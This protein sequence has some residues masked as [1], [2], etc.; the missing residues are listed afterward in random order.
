MTLYDF[1]YDSFC[2]QIFNEL[3]RLVGHY[4]SHKDGSTVKIRSG[5]VITTTN[6]LKFISSLRVERAIDSLSSAGKL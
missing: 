1:L 3:G 6:K 2:V 4:L 5:T